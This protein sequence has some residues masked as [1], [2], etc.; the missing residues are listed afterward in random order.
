MTSRLA[1]TISVRAA[2]I[3]APALA[4]PAAAPEMERLFEAIGGTWSTIVTY[5]RTPATPQGGTG[6]GRETAR[7]GPGR[8]TM[9]IEIRSNGPSGPFEA[10]G[11][12]NWSAEEQA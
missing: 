1:T 6:S 4:Q 9:I 12:I 11:V 2:L 5:E 8:H 7:P 10:F 3:A